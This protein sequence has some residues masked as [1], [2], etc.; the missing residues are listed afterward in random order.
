[1][2]K[3]QLIE[4][5]CYIIKQNTKEIMCKVEK[6]DVL[7]ENMQSNNNPELIP[8]TAFFIRKQI[9][10]VCLTTAQHFFK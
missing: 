10:A 5:D 1:M 4:T 3:P 9:S 8:S 2:G 7:Y 6:L